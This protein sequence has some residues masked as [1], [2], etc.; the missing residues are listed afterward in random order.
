[1]FSSTNSHPLQLAVCV[2]LSLYLRTFDAF[3]RPFKAHSVA[4]SQLPHGAPLPPGSLWKTRSSHVPS[5][6][7]CDWHRPSKTLTLNGSDRVT[8]ACD[9]HTGMVLYSLLLLLATAFA[10]TREDLEYCWVH[11]EVSKMC[12]DRKCQMQ[13]CFVARLQPTRMRWLGMYV[14]CRSEV[15]MQINTPSAE[16]TQ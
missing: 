11:G 12:V 10:T 7:V 14:L 6:A 15:Y 5:S 8:R 16:R 4:R 1:M 9:T 3:R 13:I 2:A